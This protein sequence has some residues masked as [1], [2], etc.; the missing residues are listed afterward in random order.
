MSVID[1][2]LSHPIFISLSLY[3]KLQVHTNTSNSDSIPHNSF[4]QICF[5]YLYL[6]FQH[7]P[8]SSIYF[9]ISL[10]KLISH[11]CGLP[12]PSHV[13]LHPCEGLSPLLRM[14]TL[15]GPAKWFSGEKK[16]RK[17]AKEVFCFVLLLRKGREEIGRGWQEKKPGYFSKMKIHHHWVMCVH[18]CAH[19]RIHT[20]TA[21]EWLASTLRL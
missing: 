20:L 21:L 11:S 7:L 2:R 14:S 4:Q 19:T 18:L 15:I 8:L 9:S 16:R 3:W 13:G 10:I 6:L 5:A 1:L 12:I 17:K